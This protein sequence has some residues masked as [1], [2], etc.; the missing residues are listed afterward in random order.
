MYNNERVRGTL[1]VKTRLIVD[2]RRYRPGVGGGGRTSPP[3]PCA[4][5][6]HRPPA[7]EN[8]SPE[9]ALLPV[10]DE[11]AL[12]DFPTLNHGITLDINVT[13]GHF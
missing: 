3:A 6:V 11:T 9:R 7:R 10:D 5:A 4:A 1:E 12:A 13:T 2:I 8:G